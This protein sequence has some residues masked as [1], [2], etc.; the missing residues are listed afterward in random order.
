MLMFSVQDQEPSKN[1][2]MPI[3]KKNYAICENLHSRFEKQKHQTCVTWDFSDFFD[4]SRNMS[5]AKVKK[6]AVDF[7]SSQKIWN[8]FVNGEL[9]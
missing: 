3:K 5:N 8:V 4:L 1:P 6:H 9:A 2:M 7:Q